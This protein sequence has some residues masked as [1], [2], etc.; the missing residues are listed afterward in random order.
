[1]LIIG[2]T[3][4]VHPDDRD[5][6]LDSVAAV[7]PPS[8]AEAGCLVYQFSVD[9]WDPNRICL[10]EVWADQ[11]ALDRHLETPHFLSYRDRTSGLRQTRNINRYN[12][13]TIAS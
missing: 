13:E 1:M 3:V 9:P 6:Y 4:D 8:R 5:T 12:A 2:G 11:E 10:F 7:T